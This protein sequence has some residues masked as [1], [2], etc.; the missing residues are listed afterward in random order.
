MKKMFTFLFLFVMVA[1]NAQISEFVT[2]GGFEN[3]TVNPDVKESSWA[4]K[5]VWY[6]RFGSWKNAT[7]ETVT[8]PEKGVAV[9][10]NYSE[11][12]QD[13]DNGPYLYQRIV[14]VPVAGKATVGFWAKSSVENPL[15]N[16]SLRLWQ[17]GTYIFRERQAFKLNDFDWPS[18]SNDEGRSGA[19]QNF[20][21]TAEWAYYTTDVD[22][23]KIVSELAEPSWAKQNGREYSIVGAD[24]DDR[25][26]F[27]IAFQGVK[28]AGEIFIAGVSLQAE[29]AQESSIKSAN[30]EELE[31]LVIGNNVML[32]NAKG[33]TGLY[34]AKGQLIDKKNP[35][36]NN[37]VQFTAL[38]K[39]F[40]IVKSSNSFQKILVR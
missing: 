25:K 26:N 9:K 4:E 12:N 28:T 36:S 39:G 31:V 8:D 14:D 5:G 19:C 38:E 18:N 32:S 21:L 35:D 37:T 7:F 17:Y 1:A 15:V 40:Y 10:M 23:T 24:D 20:N 6:T 22:L 33:E 29:K 13:R 27:L 16:V 11:S 2:D 30:G 34:N 3:T